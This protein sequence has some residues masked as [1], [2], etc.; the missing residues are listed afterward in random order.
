MRTVCW[1]CLLSLIVVFLCC[2]E[3][4]VQLLHEGKRCPDDH[5]LLL[6]EKSPGKKS[7]R[8]IGSVIVGAVGSLI[9]G[10]VAGSKNNDESEVIVITPPPL[11]PQMPST[12]NTTIMGVEY[13]VTKVN[14]TNITITTYNRNE[15]N[16]FINRTYNTID[17]TKKF[18]TTNLFNLTIGTINFKK[19][20]NPIGLFR[21]HQDIFTIIPNLRPAKIPIPKN[22]LR[23]SLWPSDWPK[24]RPPG[25]KLHCKKGLTTIGLEKLSEGKGGEVGL[26][27]FVD[28]T[29]D[30]SGFSDCRAPRG[31]PIM[32]GDVLVGIV[33]NDCT[34][35]RLHG[36]LS[37]TPIESMFDYIVD[38][39]MGDVA[40]GTASSLPT[41]TEPSAATGLAVET[42][43]G[44]LLLSLMITVYVILEK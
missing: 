38:F 27:C 37:Y 40:N 39:M 29:V 21:L 13:H 31:G 19:G 25:T 35:S 15:T 22:R 14:N 18:T 41:T 10:I 43:L 30:G 6:M 33:N 32:C 8:L 17:N 9:A 36:E 7:A 4:N 23:S 5:V 24:A 20:D 34:K 42:H 11:P 44:T 16:Y 1:K 3:S 26:R 2:Q 12:S 28:E